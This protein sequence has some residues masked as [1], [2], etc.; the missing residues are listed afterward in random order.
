MGAAAFGSTKAE[1]AEQPARPKNEPFGYCLNTSTIRGQK[2]PLVE[3][4][5]IAAK[6]GYTGDRA[7]AFQ[8]RGV[9]EDGRLAQGPRPS[10]SATTA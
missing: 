2:L 4:I 7:V 1:A 10:G 9:H 6:A 5:E 8:D 3:E